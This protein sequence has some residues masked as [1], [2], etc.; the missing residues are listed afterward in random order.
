MMAGIL[1]TG[2]LIRF[3][4]LLEIMKNPDFSSLVLDA[5][6]HDYWARG[7]ATGDWPSSISGDNPLISGTPY[8]KPPGY[9]YFLALIYRIFGPGYLVPRIFQMGLGLGNCVL[10]FFLGKKCFGEATGIIFA[11]LM[12]SCWILVYF[13]GEFYAPVFLIFLSLLVIYSLSALTEKISFLRCATAGCI[14]G[15]FALIRS[16]ILLFAPVAVAWFTWI[17]LRRKDEASHVKDETSLVRGIAGFLLGIMLT[18]APATIRNY[19]VAN[20]FVFISSNGGL[21][22][23]VGNHHTSDGISPIIPELKEMTG[24]E[25]WTPYHYPLLIRGLERKLDKPL[26]HSQASAY[27]VGKAINHVREHPWE[28]LAL[29]G[30]K[31][32]AF[33]GPVEIANPTEVHYDRMDSRVLQNMPGNFPAV[34][35]LSILGIA[36]L[37]LNLRLSFNKKEEKILPLSKKQYEMSLLVLLFIATYF[38]SFLPFLVSSRF[39]VPIIPF[40]LLFGSYGLYQM[41]HFTINRDLRKAATCIVALIA[42]YIFTSINWIGYKPDEAKWRFNRGTAYE[43]RGRMDLALSEYFHAIQI[44]PLYAEAYNGLGN[45]L[46]NQGKLGD[47]VDHYSAAIRI[48]PTFAEAH[49]NLGATLLEQGKSDEAAAHFSKVIEISPFDAKSYYKMGLVLIHQGKHD[50]AITH[51]SKTLELK[52]D[53]AEAHNNLGRA[54]ADQGKLDEAVF[55]YY[56]ALRVMPDDVKTHNNLGIALLRLGKPDEAIARYGDALRINP[57]DEIVH[58]NIGIALAEQGK[59]QEAIAHYSSVS[60]LRSA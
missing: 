36:L 35:S 15:L 28:W 51:F 19:T 25:S 11:F 22:L 3:L 5:S 59:L 39:R 53:F 18:V 6:F 40:L 58:L 9:P 32:L 26:K 7:L 54:L 27:W 46:A 38:V 52:P 20:D 47:A 10:A 17:S 30:K 2:F 13:E 8:Q 16:N 43:A 41:Y 57:A 37:F 24:L 60:L 48:K 49:N 4:Y 34:L 42:L 56:E 1:L 29:T 33:W 12:S 21:N 31:I 44:R 45:V 14:L 50:E 55:H 23:L